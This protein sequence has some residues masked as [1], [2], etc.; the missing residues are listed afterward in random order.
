[1]S[2]SGW[3]ML[4]YALEA[5]I[6][7]SRS[8]LARSPLPRVFLIVKPRPVVNIKRVSNVCIKR[9][10]AFFPRKSVHSNGLFLKRLLSLRIYFVFN[11]INFVH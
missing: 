5:I 3:G 8:C 6:L 4:V 1:M 2:K 10:K 7:P 11:E 9:F